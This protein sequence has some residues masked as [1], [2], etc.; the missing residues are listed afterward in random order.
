MCFFVFG[1]G[2]KRRGGG[3]TSNQLHL[4]VRARMWTRFDNRSFVVCR[5]AVLSI[6]FDVIGPAISRLINDAIIGYSCTW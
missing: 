2:G 3:K 1:G 5:S 6:A 4:S